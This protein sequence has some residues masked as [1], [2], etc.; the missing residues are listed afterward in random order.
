MKRVVVTGMGAVT[1]LG[2]D[3][4]T[5]WN[6]LVAGASGAAT[7]TRFDPS[8]FRTRFACELKNYD[9][10]LALDKAELRKTDPF[11]QYALSATAEAVA[12]AGIDFAAMNPFD[13]G[14]IWGSGQGGMQTF[15]EQVTEY[16][17]G[18]NIPRFSPYFVPRLIANMASGMISM[19]YGLMGIN[20]TTVSACATSNTAIM[21]ALNYIRLGKAK[22]IITGGSEAPIT[23]ASVG[24]FCAMKAMSTRNEDP[25]T[26][27]RPF[28]TERDGFVMGEGAG[29][30]I[31]E[32]Y[33]HA[34]ARGAKIYA[35]VAGA[36]MTADAYH[37]TAT[38]PEGLGA[39]QAMKFALEDAGLN[40]TDVDYLNA[41]ATST[42]VGDLSEIKAITRLFGDDPSH[43]YISATKSMTG[44]LLGAAGAIEAI[45]AILSID[46][47][48]IPPTIN[49]TNLDPEIPANLQ[50]VLGNALEKDVKV[51]ISNTF[52]FGGHNGIVVF[53]KI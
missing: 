50:I 18:G 34:K 5:F 1:P 51:A 47:K 15:E 40:T 45:A 20:Y 37:M 4:N 41:H 33:E 39:F 30:L 2:N 35:E 27:A 8:K 23:P 32:E 6:Q 3:V 22:V 17:N 13:T 48:L 12:D 52:G 10:T 16:V 14:V 19:K 46:K 26:A 29:A 25:A 36:A 7:I 44:H 49:T 38:H 43:L 24:G 53:R 42:P 21:D 31:L 9:P 11:T 28:D